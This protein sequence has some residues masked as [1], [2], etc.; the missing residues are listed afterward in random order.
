L[1]RLVEPLNRG[2]PASPLRRTC[3]SVRELAAAPQ[4]QGHRVSRQL[5]MELLH[6]LDYSLHG[7]RKTLEGSDRPDRDAQFVHL[8]AHVHAQLAAG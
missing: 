6:D 2:D 8:D 1:E 4:A 7:N 3:K 5:V